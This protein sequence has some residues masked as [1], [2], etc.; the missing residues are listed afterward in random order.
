MYAY[1]GDYVNAGLSAGAMVPF[2]GWGVTGLKYTGKLVK[3]TAI[4]KDVM[5][6][7]AKIGKE[8]V[9]GVSNFTLKE[10]K[11]FLNQLHLD[12]SKAGAIGRKS[13]WDMAKDLGKQFGVD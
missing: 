1:E 10:E 4:D 3:I 7:T 6:F 9:E 12:G 8:T 13:M 2:L 11:L 5:M